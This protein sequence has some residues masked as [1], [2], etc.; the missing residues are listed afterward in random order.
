VARRSMNHDRHGHDHRPRRRGGR[1]THRPETHP[2]HRL[3]PLLGHPRWLIT[4]GGG[5]VRHCRHSATHLVVADYSVANL[6]NAAD[7]LADDQA[8]GR[9][10]LVRADLNALPFVDAAFDAAVVLRVLHR[11]PDCESALA[12]MGRT[13]GDRWLI[14]VPIAHPALDGLRGTAGQDAS[15]GSGPAPPGTGARG[16]SAPNLDVGPVRRLLSEHGWQS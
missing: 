3:L 4:F 11:L 14:D 5:S 6:V 12:E 9:A 7:V 2:P 13:V 16:D 8:A 1:Y 15:E 10:F